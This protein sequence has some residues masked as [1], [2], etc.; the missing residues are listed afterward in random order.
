MGGDNVKLGTE[1]VSYSSS[2]LCLMGIHGGTLY[3]M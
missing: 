2:R 1:T 3:Y